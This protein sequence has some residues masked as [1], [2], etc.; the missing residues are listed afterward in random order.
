[1][2]EEVFPY[3]SPDHPA[4]LLGTALIVSA[5]GAGSAIGAGRDA[6]SVFGLCIAATAGLGSLHS[7]LVRL[8]DGRIPGVGVVGGL[9]PI[10]V[11]HSGHT[12]L[13]LLRRRDGAGAGVDCGGV[14]AV[15]AYSLAAQIG[16]AIRGRCTESEQ[17]T[18][19]YRRR[20]HF[21]SLDSRIN[22]APCV[23]TIINRNH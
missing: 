12:A 3:S 13:R 16:D 18:H 1:M 5:L 15:A 10:A 2:Y 4:P 23:S 14:L 22:G 7:V 6:L 19:D 21:A 9:G 8:R 11:L 20:L 17:Q